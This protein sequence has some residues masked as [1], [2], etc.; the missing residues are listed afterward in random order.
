MKKIISW[1]LLG[2]LN[3]CKSINER[4]IMEERG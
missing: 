4:G 1:G 3:A 2:E